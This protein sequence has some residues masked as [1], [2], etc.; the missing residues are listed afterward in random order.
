MGPW[1]SR[2]SNAG[3]RRR[4]AST[5][6]ARALR[7]SPWSSSSS[8]HRPGRPAGGGHPRRG[9]G[10]PRP[11]RL[12]GRSSWRRAGTPPSASGVPCGTPCGVRSSRARGVGCCGSAGSAWRSDRP[13]RSCG[14]A[15]WRSAT[16]GRLPRTR[17]RSSVG[18]RARSGWSCSGRRN[19]SAS[20]PPRAS[21]PRD[22][23][24][25]GGRGRRCRCG[26][27]SGRGR[28]VGRSSGSR[29]VVGVD[30]GTRGGTSAPVTRPCT[31]CGRWCRMGHEERGSHDRAVDEPEPLPARGVRPRAR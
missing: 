4:R 13:R 30:R 28:P 5:S 23:S 6:V 19:R 3:S 15:R 29:S 26:C 16:S 24:T 20:I 7:R 11:V 21:V 25:S 14:G 31:S 9:R 22:G 1:R 8:R 17:S 10:A 27:R 18:A 2:A 12:R